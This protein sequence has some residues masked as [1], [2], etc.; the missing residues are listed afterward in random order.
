MRQRAAGFVAE[1][2]RQLLEADLD[3]LGGQVVDGEVGR[4]APCVLAESSHV[5]GVGG[6]RWVS[7]AVCSPT[8][9]CI[10]SRSGAGGGR[11]PLQSLCGSW[12]TT[13]AC[14]L[15]GATTAAWW[16][17]GL[18]S[19][20]PRQFAVWWDLGVRTKSMLTLDASR[21][22]L[23]AVRAVHGCK[24]TESLSGGS[25][26]VAQSHEMPK[27]RVPDV[28]KLFS[29]LGVCRTGPGL[30]GRHLRGKHGPPS[31]VQ[32]GMPSQIARGGARSMF[33]PSSA[34]LLRPPAVPL[35]VNPAITTSIT[36]GCPKYFVLFAMVLPC[37]MSSIPRYYLMGLSLFALFF[38]SA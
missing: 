6:T 22:Y 28:A 20:L 37:V 12:P 3:V 26:S 16:K 1:E 18:A 17:P 25:C 29:R 8:A 7:Q 32:S 13:A 27:C 4:V 38:Y 15:R 11:G 34:R 23:L 24:T 2:V 30:V 10:P 31:G 21:N 9:G 14:V 33:V 35:L 36:W 5:S 19:S